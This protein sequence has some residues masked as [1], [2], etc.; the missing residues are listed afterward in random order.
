LYFGSWNNNKVKGSNQ[1][2]TDQ[3]QKPR[4]NSMPYYNVHSYHGNQNNSSSN[5]NTGNNG[6]SGSFS[7]F[8]NTQTSNLNNK[9]QHSASRE[10]LNQ[11]TLMQQQHHMQ[12]NQ[13]Q[14][15]PSNTNNTASYHR[16]SLNNLTP[17]S[18][19]N[20][21][22]Q[23]F[24]NRRN[25]S[26]GADRMMSSGSMHSPLGSLSSNEKNLSDQNV[27]S[28]SPNFITNIKAPTTSDINSRLE[29]LCRQMT[30]QAI[31]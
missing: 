18:M 23:Q 2:V 25:S 10:K 27:S 19:Q 20:Q 17:F 9:F 29:S 1:N 24:G 7:N 5:N 3:N 12:F 26:C 21:Q 13:Q 8:N 30:E 31:N 22:Q 15:V 28:T 4:K 11:F 16:N 6:K 14:Q